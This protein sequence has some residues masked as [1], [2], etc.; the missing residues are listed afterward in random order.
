MLIDTLKKAAAEAAKRMDT[1]A[2]DV[3]R[4]AQGEI[5]QAEARAEAPLS[6]EQAIQVVRKLIKS[7]EET[8]VH[9]DAERR[10]TLEREVEVLK[11]L[12]PRSLSVSEIAT[13]LEPVRDAIQGAKN[14]GQ[15]TGVAMKHLKGSG[16]EVTGKDVTEA[17]RQIR[18]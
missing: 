1:V 14:D 4:L 17:V 8:L 6:E 5:Q 2:R 10:A 3:L 15:A 9:A 7:N 16:V 13:L 11:V 12:L 18:G